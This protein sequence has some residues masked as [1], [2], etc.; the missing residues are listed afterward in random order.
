MIVFAVLLAAYGFYLNQQIKE[1]L[2][3]KVW[4][5]PA[6]VY[7]RMVNLEPGMDYSQAEM[8]RLLEG[9]QYRKVSKITTS[10]EV[11]VRGNTIEILRRPF[12]FPDQKEGRITGAYGVWKQ[13]IK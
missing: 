5:L 3:G 9:M 2:D 7:G 10:G 11:V 13:F 4:D 8:T 1:R 12:N 6:A